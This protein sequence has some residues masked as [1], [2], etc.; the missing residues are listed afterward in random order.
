MSCVIKNIDK[1]CDLNIINLSINSGSFNNTAIDIEFL[2]E[3]DIEIGSEGSL[4][5]LIGASNVVPFFESAEWIC[6]SKAISKSESGVK[7]RMSFQDNF[8]KEANETYIG[9]TN[10]VGGDILLGKE[11][12]TINDSIHPDGINVPGDFLISRE[13]LRLNFSRLY[14]GRNYVN[15]SGQIVPNPHHWSNK[16]TKAEQEAALENDAFRGQYPNP[17]QDFGEILYTFKNLINTSKYPV[18]NIDPNEIVGLFNQS[19][20]FFDCMNS[21]LNTYGKIFVANP[22][23]GGYY[24]HDAAVDLGKIDV[25]KDVG[26]SPPDSAISSNISNDMSSGYSSSAWLRTFRKGYWVEDDGRDSGEQ[27]NQNYENF[28]YHSKSDE[29]EGLTSFNLA[30]LL[31]KFGAPDNN[32]GIFESPSNNNYLRVLAANLAYEVMV[33]RGFARDANI[34]EYM[35]TTATRLQDQNDINRI[36]KKYDLNLPMPSG[37]YY[38]FVDGENTDVIQIMDNG[39][40]NHDPSG[41]SQ[42]ELFFKWLMQSSG[43]NFPNGRIHPDLIRVF[44]SK[45]NSINYIQRFNGKY[46]TQ[47]GDKRGSAYP[48]TTTE[49]FENFGTSRDPR[50]EKNWYSD[51]GIRPQFH[52]DLSQLADSPFGWALPYVDVDTLHDFY[53]SYGFWLDGISAQI[54]AGSERYGVAFT[55][56]GDYPHETLQESISMLLSRYDQRM[57]VLADKENVSFLE[58]SAYSRGLVIIP[59]TGLS[60]G[61]TT[62]TLHALALDLRNTFETYLKSPKHRFSD[63]SQ[64]NF[65]YYGEAVQG[66]PSN[67]YTSIQGAGSDGRLP[68]GGSNLDGLANR[69]NVLR[70]EGFYTNAKDPI[71]HP[72]RRIANYSQEISNVQDQGK[73]ITYIDQSGKVNYAAW[74]LDKYIYVND[75]A[76]INFTLINEL[77]DF[78]QVPDWIKYLEAMDISI[79]SGILTANYT[80]SQRILIPDYLGREQA[81]AELQ[82][83]ILKAYHKRY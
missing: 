66:R 15:L 76:R 46:L 35:L 27:G 64:V 59:K 5:D 43:K 39:F 21:I 23:L 51:I 16:T 14:S 2:G 6:V 26:I 19:G 31:N 33:D 22:L 56:K 25:L 47:N 40:N 37:N 28:I 63:N 41:K 45:R 80:F 65:S 20:S 12:F 42:S 10:R 79:T 38:Y 53:R 50:G 36:Y 71:K 8:S 69:V 1:Y 13:F 4:K 11:Y 81:R 60:S 29:S 54:S 24:V 9:L 34:A 72:N 30:I 68:N 18:Q 3:N 17:F 58:E 52:L 82:S 7:T 78:S 48:Y 61:L 62:S 77:I 57:E 75:L 55:D 44:M 49:G 74:K 83:L 67:S 70:S 73:Q 32:W